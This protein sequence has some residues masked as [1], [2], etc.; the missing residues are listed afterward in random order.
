MLSGE[1]EWPRCRLLCEL[2]AASA[3]VASMT[4]HYPEPFV[5]QIYSQ[6]AMP[7]VSQPAELSVAWALVCILRILASDS[8]QPREEQHD[9]VLVAPPPG[10]DPPS[11]S[12][13]SG[14]EQQN[15]L[16]QRCKC[17]FCSFKCCRAGRPHKVHRCKRHTNW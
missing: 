16:T 10:L 11:Y 15:R 5:G 1:K 6:L 9:T 2:I 8:L 14:R 17:H 3:P 4:S 13:A 7:A 12:V